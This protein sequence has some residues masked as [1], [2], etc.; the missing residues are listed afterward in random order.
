MIQLSKIFY[1]SLAIVLSLLN[2]PSHATAQALPKILVFSKTEGYR[3]KSIEAGILAIQKLGQ[4]NGFEV[5]ATEDAMIFTNDSLTKFRAIIFLSTSG[6]VLNTDQEKALQTF[7]RAG[8][9]F[10]GIHGAS[11]TEYDW[12]WYGQLVG[13]YFNKHPAVQPATLN[14]VE[15][16]HP[17]TQHL[18]EIWQRTDEWYN[19][20]DIQ[21]NIQVLI[22]VDETSYTGGTNGK[23]H[24]FAWYQEFDGGRSFYTAG[25]HADKHY[26]EPA[27]LQHILGGILWAMGE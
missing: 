4:E 2:T 9:G 23:N 24:P 20:K 15:K 8:K 5:Q 19:F 14:V 21:S 16:N 12:P 7:I 11:T 13:A 1:F 25:G 17:A 6:D 3:H 26:Q 27:F 18:P 22:T 10:A